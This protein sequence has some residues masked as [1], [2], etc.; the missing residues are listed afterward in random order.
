MRKLETYTHAVI[1]FYSIYLEAYHAALKCIRPWRFK[2]IGDCRGEY[3]RAN[4]IGINLILAWMFA[5]KWIAFT[6]GFVII[7][8]SRK[9]GTVYT[10][11]IHPVVSVFAFGI[12]ALFIHREVRSFILALVF[13]NPKRL[14]KV[15]N[16]KD[17][18]GDMQSSIGFIPCAS[19]SAR[20]N[21][22]DADY[23]HYLFH[24]LS[25][26]LLYRL[27]KSFSGDTKIICE[28]A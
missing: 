14:S 11:T 19:M 16:H 28:A 12:A 8:F 18:I 6:M 13:H 26:T 5:K 27:V 24:A 4:E 1:V 9:I 22:Q 20:S 3:I 25:I 23:E 21:K 10:V 15:C 7:P 17:S 2:P